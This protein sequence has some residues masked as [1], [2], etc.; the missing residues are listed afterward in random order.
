MILFC[1]KLH[2]QRDL[3]TMKS[4]ELW[5]LNLK[6]LFDWWLRVTFPWIPYLSLEI[7][8][9]L[10]KLNPFLPVPGEKFKIKQITENT[11]KIIKAR[12]L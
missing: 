3:W 8:L 4:R 6:Y 1:P 11:V 12:K 7:K 2:K 9:K 5:E 10:K